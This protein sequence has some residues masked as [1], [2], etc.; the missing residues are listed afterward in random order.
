M[1]DQPGPIA[2]TPSAPSRRSLLR[3][4]SLGAAV[5]GAAPLLAACGGSSKTSSAGGGGGGGKTTVRMWTWYN[6]QQKEFP[7]LIKEFEAKNP[8]ITVQ[9]RLFG[10]PDQYL[11]ALAA[12]VSGGDVPEI[13]A[14][15]IRALTYG[16]AGVSADL[17]KDLG[18]NFLKD[19]FT[20]T[21]DEYTLDGKQYALGWMAQTFGIFYNPDLMKAAGVDGE[22]ATWDELIAAAAK[23]NASGKKA[24]AIS[25]SPSTS[26]LDF[27]LPLLA[28][29]ANDPTFYLRLDKLDGVTY[30]DPTVVKS[31]Q[32]LQKLVKAN[33]FQPG[34][35]RHV[36]RPGEPALL[37]RGLGDA[38][39]TA[40]GHPRD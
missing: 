32:L 4:G 40:H 34:G 20:S 3:Y 7:R 11:P 21:N 31:L 12:A 26:G 27:F 39:Q 14:P 17:K 16:K 19:F 2:S 29:Y 33:V 6:E 35:Q 22:P 30:T 15:H 10:T 28:Q 23:V 9:N 25:A 18:S 13:F 36:Q 8:S 24:V 1:A 37:H 38:V 5:L